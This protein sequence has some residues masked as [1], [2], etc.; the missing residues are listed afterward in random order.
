MRTALRPETLRKI[1]DRLAARYDWRH[2]LLTAGSDEQGRRL[3]VRHTVRPGDQ[4][5]DAGG[6]TGG[7]ALLAAAAASPTGH[8]TVFD[9]SAAMLAQ[10]HRKANVAGLT[11]RMSFA[12]GDMHRLP[13]PDAAFDAV[14]TT[15]SLC[16]LTD[17]VL[18]A[19]ELYRVLRPG[20]RLGAAHS[21]QPRQPVVRWLADRLD[22]VVWRF[23][24]LSM[25]CRAVTVLPSLLQGGA[26]LVFQQRLGIPLYPFLVFVVE[27]PRAEHMQGARP[28]NASGL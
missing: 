5:L 20:G 9:L 25:G 3:V 8:V 14:L 18:G 22:D 11:E 4:V 7:T 1:Y 24:N 23:P 21:T 15:Y 26:R 13:Y 17:P 12:V 2:G 10:A 16:P 27:K 19:R 6:G 28:K